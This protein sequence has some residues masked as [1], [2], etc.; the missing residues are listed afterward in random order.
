MKNLILILFV[1]FAS[2]SFAQKPCKVKV[3]YKFDHIIEGYDHTTKSIVYIDGVQVEES[4]EHLQSTPMS[5]SFTTP[6]GEHEI[7][8]VTFT[9]YEGKWEERSVAN[10]YSTEGFVQQR[11]KFGKKKSIN[12]TFDIDIVDPIVVIK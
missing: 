5:V 9:Y 10:G 2:F 7:R 1:A 4:R 8:I 6:K 3:S 12:I 11:L